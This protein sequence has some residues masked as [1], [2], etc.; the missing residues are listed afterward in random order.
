MDHRNLQFMYSITSGTLSR[1][2]AQ[3]NERVLRIFTDEIR[4]PM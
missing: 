3:R 1:L 2:R 4:L